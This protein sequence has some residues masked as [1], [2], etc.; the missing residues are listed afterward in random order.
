MVRADERRWQFKKTV[1][2]DAGRR[3]RDE[4]TLQLRKTKKSEQLSKRRAA[5]TNAQINTAEGD[6]ESVQQDANRQPP[7]SLAEVPHL[8][9][10]MQNSDATPNE[11]LDAVRGV[12]RMLSVEENP[13]AKQLIESGILPLMIRFLTF[14]TEPMLQFEAAWA[15]TNIASTH[16]TA[17]VVNAGA[18]PGLVRLLECPTPNVREQAAWCI[19]NIAGDSIELRDVVLKSGA[20]TSLL[21]NVSNPDSMSLLKNVV[22]AISNL[23]RGTPKPDFVLIRDCIP[24][25]NYAI[26]H[27]KSSD[28]ARTDALWALSYLSDGEDFRIQA[29]VDSGQV[30]PHA[31]NALRCE[32]ASL[33]APALRILGNIV[34]GNAEQTQAVLDAGILG[35]VPKLLEN[36]RKSIRKETTW[37]LSNIAAGTSE[38]VSQICMN[39]SLVCS[40][41]GLSRYAPW[42]VR[43]EAIWCI[44]NLCSSGTATPKQIQML[45][46]NDVIEAMSDVLDLT[47]A[48]L[49]L[50]ALDAIESILKLGKERG[51]SYHV[52]FEEADGISKLENLQHHTNDKVYDKAVELIETYYGVEDD[53]GDENLMPEESSDGYFAFGMSSTTPKNLFGTSSPAAKFDFGGNSTPS[54]PRS[55]RFNANHMNT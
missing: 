33:M 43:K 28:E 24:A 21:R 47:D 10:V 22:W 55:P 12:R 27:E 32:K 2:S 13:P 39:H 5:S 16:Y 29:V 45:V 15:L 48:V 17:Q 37:L 8:I 18:M 36:S 14:D 38:Q 49:V 30:V 52:F 25:M 41:I 31:M 20:L 6:T 19:G 23:C 26:V 50:V 4:T 42:E 53:E 3:R 11:R 54:F 44:S 34:T 46:D 35:I 1:D 51:K 9:R 40:L 7:P